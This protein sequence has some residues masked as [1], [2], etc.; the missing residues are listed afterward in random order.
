[1]TLSK[2]RDSIICCSFCSWSDCNILIDP[3]TGGVTAVI[4]WEMAGFCPLWLA[5]VAT[6]WFNDDS[7][8][9]LI[10]D[11]Q[12][13]CQSCRRSINWRCDSCPLPQLAVLDQRDLSPPPSGINLKAVETLEYDWSSARITSGRGNFPFDLMAWINE[14]IDLGEQVS[15]QVSLMQSILSFDFNSVKANGATPDASVFQLTLYMCLAC[16]SFLWITHRFLTKI[17]IANFSGTLC[18]VH[19]EASHPLVAII[20]ESPSPSVWLGPTVTPMLEKRL[21]SRTCRE[22]VSTLQ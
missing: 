18:A 9:F 12:L 3:N 17:N 1:M 22:S 16:D 20:L 11:L 6:G 10:S 21:Q 19:S 13:L 7:E 2:F 15:V 8:L 5:A 14:R 4:D